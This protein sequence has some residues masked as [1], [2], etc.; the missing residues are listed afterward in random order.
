MKS[1]LFLLP[2][3]IATAALAHDTWIAPDQFTGACGAVTLHMTSGETFGAL[4]HAID[5]RRVARAVALIPGRRLDLKPEAAAHSADFRVDVPEKGITI[6]AVELAPKTID[7]TPT[8]VAE[9]LEEID[10]PADVRA[11][12]KAHPGRWRETYTKHAKTFL[13]CGKTDYR[14]QISA[15]MGLELI[16]QGTDPTT[17]KAGDTFRVALIEPRHL[18]RDVSLILVREGSGR[19]AVVKPEAS[20]VASFVIPQPGRYEMAATRLRPGDGNDAD[21]VSDFTTLTFEVK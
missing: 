1:L 21:W 14:H 10:A 3:S 15:D 12:W 2:L 20:G 8:E 4:D 9:Y 19:V 5:P 11:A 17:L 18:V 6:V 7:L 13:R 16:P